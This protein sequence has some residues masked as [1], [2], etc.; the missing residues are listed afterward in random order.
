M[1]RKYIG[2]DDDGAA[3]NAAMRNAFKSADWQ[4]GED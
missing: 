3:K 2:C 1:L 4:H